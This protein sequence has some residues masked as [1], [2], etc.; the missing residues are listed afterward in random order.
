MQSALIAHQPA[1]AFEHYTQAALPPYR[2]S[3]AC[4]AL[5]HLLTRGSSLSPTSPT[6]PTDPHT[7]GKGK[8]RAYSFA[9]PPTSP[10]VEDR[11]SESAS[12]L[13]RIASRILSFF[14]PAEPEVAQSPPERVYTDIVS[15]GWAIPTD[16]KK[17]VRDVE[18]M[19]VAGGWYV[20]G[21]GWIVDGQHQ[22]PLA[23]AIIEFDEEDEG[24]HSR[25]STITPQKIRRKLQEEKDASTVITFQSKR[26]KPKDRRALQVDTP[27]LVGGDKESSSSEG[28]MLKT[29]PGGGEDE[30][31]PVGPVQDTETTMKLLVC[32]PLCRLSSRD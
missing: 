7:S 14:A 23:R 15:N 28:T 19:G 9:S 3:A 27:G 17:A 22:L 13:P 2:S 18:G 1:L 12:A 31:A 21:L 10:I 8:A 32:L 4:L 26:V 5:G 6:S 11:P 16:G 29:P 24:G 30:L 20:L 25:C